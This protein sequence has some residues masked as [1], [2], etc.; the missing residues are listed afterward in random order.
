[1][2]EPSNESLGIL[3]NLL[4]D[5]IDDFVEEAL[6]TNPAIEEEEL[7]DSLRTILYHKV[8]ECLDGG[9]FFVKI[10][11]KHNDVFK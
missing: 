2:H 8:D 10:I 9:E 7:V 6:E 4:G 1:M 3:S 5:W 11:G